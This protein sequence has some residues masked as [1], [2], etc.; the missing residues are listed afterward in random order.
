MFILFSTGKVQTTGTTS[1]PSTRRHPCVADIVLHRHLLQCCNSGI[2]PLV[3]QNYQSGFNSFIKF[4]FQFGITPFV[5]EPLTL[6]YF[7]AHIST[8][9]IKDIKGI[10]ILAIQLTYSKVYLTPPY[11]QF[12]YPSIYIS[13][14][15]THFKEGR[16][17]H[18]CGL[19]KY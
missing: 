19:P 7:C 13:L 4:C 2:A 3:C 16:L 17:H 10:P 1:K 6:E 18:S 9:L 5:V 14:K 8:C 12:K 15:Q 11:L